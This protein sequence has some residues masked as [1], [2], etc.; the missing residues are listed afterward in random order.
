VFSG[1][2]RA[3]SRLD[4]ATTGGGVAVGVA[5]GRRLSVWTEL[6]A[7]GQS[8]RSGAP[9]YTVVNETSLEAV[10]G[11]WLK[12]SPQLRTAYGDTSGGTFRLGLEA[13]WLPRAHWNLD[14]SFYRD[15]DRATTLVSH[16]WLGQVHL[17]L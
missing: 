6:D 12:V 17:Y 7:Q 15:R 9:L 10:R 13:D 2:T 16:T 3:S 11:L 4:P 5:P 14:A 1:L 8:G